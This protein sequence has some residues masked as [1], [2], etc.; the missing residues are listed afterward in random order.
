MT[1][2]VFP[3]P[4]TMTMTTI[5]IDLIN[6]NC[7][8]SLDDIKIR[9]FRKSKEIEQYGY[10]FGKKLEKLLLGTKESGNPKCSEDLTDSKN[11][12]KIENI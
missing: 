12:E 5:S 1:P 7:D 3:I 6:P 4:P 2:T 10:E 9:N 11:S 8:G